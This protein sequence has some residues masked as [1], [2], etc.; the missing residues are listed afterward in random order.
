MRWESKVVELETSAKN[1]SNYSDLK[2]FDYFCLIYI[3][4]W[5]DVHQNGRKLGLLCVERKGN[6]KG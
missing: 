4:I 2:G 5:V 3:L 1:S 6:G